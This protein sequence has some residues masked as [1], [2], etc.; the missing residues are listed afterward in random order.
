MTHLASRRDFLIKAGLSAAGINLAMGLPSLA[1]AASKNE[2]QKQ[3]LIF[4][5]SPNG[6][7]PKHF[8]PDANAAEATGRVRSR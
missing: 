3:R 8:W 1:E 7:I 5:F 4:V 2:G 6:V